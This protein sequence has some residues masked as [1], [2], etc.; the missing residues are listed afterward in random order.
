MPQP[1]GRTWTRVGIETKEAIS[2][3]KCPVPHRCAQAVIGLDDNREF[4]LPGGEEGRR[5]GGRKEERRGEKKESNIYL[6]YVYC[7]HILV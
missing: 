1:P 4:C 5:E 3:G 2:R 7:I 6:V